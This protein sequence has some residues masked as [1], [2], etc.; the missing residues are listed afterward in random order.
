[1]LPLLVGVLIK[2]Y[3]DFVDDIPIL[4]NAYGIAS[5]RTLTTAA[6]TLVLARDLWLCLTFAVFNVVCAWSDWTRYSGPHDVSLWGL[7][8]LCLAASWSHRP[9]FGQVDA[10]IALGFLGVALFEPIGFPEETSWC[11]AV[12][13]FLGAWVLLTAV[14][15][16]RRIGSSMRS[17]TWMFG[18]YAMA[19]SLTQVARLCYPHARHEEES[20]HSDV[21]PSSKSPPGCVGD[22]D[23]PEL[24]RA[25]N[26]ERSPVG[27]GGEE[28]REDNP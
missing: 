26:Q 11:K 19:S 7:T 4:T 8:L 21:N 18:G 13:R 3:D 20:I 10:G 9:S 5:L 16:L 22:D 27:H 25:V 1:M 28:R 23:L 14:F 17:L 24:R 6:L 15:V 2:V 12:S